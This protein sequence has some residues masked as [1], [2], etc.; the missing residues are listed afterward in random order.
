[1]RITIATQQGMLEGLSEAREDDDVVDFSPCIRAANRGRSEALIVLHSYILRKEQEEQE[2]AARARSH[3]GTSAGLS[4]NVQPPQPQINTAQQAQQVIG[5]APNLGQA[6]QPPPFRAAREP[7]IP[8]IFQTRSPTTLVASSTQSNSPPQNVTRR[9]TV[10]EPPAHI[11]TSGGDSHMPSQDHS[12]PPLHTER[13]STSSTAGTNPS[14]SSLASGIS[15]RSITD[16][17]RTTSDSSLS[18]SSPI[19]S[20]GGCCKYAHRLRDGIVKKSLMLQNQAI[21]PGAQNFLYMCSSNKCDFRGPAIQNNKRQWTVDNRIR[22]RHGLQYR[23]LFLAK[24]HIQKTNQRDGD[25]FRCIL[26]ILLGDQS[27]IFQGHDAL[28]GHVI[29]HQGAQFDHITLVGPLSFSNDGIRVDDEFD[30]NLPERPLLPESQ[31]VH[32]VPAAFDADVRK[33]LQMLDDSS[34]RSSIL[35]DELEQNHWAG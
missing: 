13:R 19:T 9:N 4:S 35:T 26:C 12:R 29:S 5:A 15:L 33:E 1:M 24:S 11:R 22:S 6:S 18:V 34:Q 20:Y 3:S 32:S 23:W 28:L 7:R 10:P 17:S 16:I 25:C 21:T 31:P 2:R 14:I 27:S 8:N 30:I